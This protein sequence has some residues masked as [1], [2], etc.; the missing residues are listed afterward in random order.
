MPARFV[1]INPAAGG[2]QASDVRLDI[3]RRVAATNA[4]CTVVETSAPGHA[5]V[6]AREHATRAEMI[7]VVGGDGTANEAANGILES[8]RPERPIAL[9]PLGTGNDFARALGIT[10]RDVA[11]RAMAEGHV[12]SVDVLRVDLLDQSQTARERRY[13]LIYAAVGFPAEVVEVVGPWT[14]KLLGSKRCYTFGSLVALLRRRGFEAVISSQG[15]EWAGAFRMVWAANIDELAGGT[16]Q[17][18]PGA[19][20]GD[21]KMEIGALDAVGRLTLLRTLSAILS[22]GTHLGMSHVRYTSGTDLRVNTPLPQ[23]I[24]IDGELWG[25]SPFS[26]SVTMKLHVVVPSLTTE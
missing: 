3:A 22:G 23:P 7:V 6:L 2:L 14:K 26:V 17:L 12:R 5:Q 19:D 8:S 20:C 15:M 9:V 24:V 18:S 4:D 16:M 1:I 25:H 13:A 10:D 21:G 11:V